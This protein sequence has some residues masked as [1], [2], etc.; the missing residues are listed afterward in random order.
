MRRLQKRVS[1]V[2]PVALLALGAA[3]CGGSSGSSGSSNSAKPNTTATVKQ[4]GTLTF[5]SEKV[6]EGFNINTSADVTFDTGLQMDPLAPWAFNNT[7]GLDVALNTDLLDSACL[8]YTSPS[9]RD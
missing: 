4:G 8:L 2:A 6:P 7:P 5:A 3:A 1:L 9:P